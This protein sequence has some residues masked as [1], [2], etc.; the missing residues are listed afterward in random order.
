MKRVHLIVLFNTTEFLMSGNL[1]LTFTF[2]PVSCSPSVRGESE[3]RLIRLFESL[4][5]PD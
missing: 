4:A 3:M 2:P 1:T 5:F